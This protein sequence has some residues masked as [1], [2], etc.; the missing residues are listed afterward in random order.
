MRERRAESG[1]RRANRRRS[2]TA[3]GGITLIEVLIAMFVL[4][5]G[6][7]GVAALLPVAQSQYKKGT[8]EQRASDL[9]TVAFQAFETYGMN[10]PSKW[11]YSDGYPFDAIQP[12]DGVRHVLRVAD[13][14]KPPAGTDPSGGAYWID[15]VPP[16]NGGDATKLADLL[17]R[18]DNNDGTTGWIIKFISG[19]LR[20]QQ[21][22]I[23]TIGDADSPNPGRF[24]FTGWFYEPDPAV[25]GEKKSLAPDRPFDVPPT[26]GDAFILIRHQPFVIDPWFVA[27]A[28]TGGT[29]GGM[30]RVSISARRKDLSD[31][32]NDSITDE[33][34]YYPMGASLAESIFVSGDDLTFDA[35]DGPKEN[36]RQYWSHEPYKDLNENGQFDPGVDEFDPDNDVNGNGV[37][38]VYRRAYDANFSW[39]AMLAP[40]DAGTS[41]R[42]YQLSTVVFYKRHLN[43]TAT[44]L[45]LDFGVNGQHVRFGGGSAKLLTPGERDAER[46]EKL[47]PGQWILVRMSWADVNDPDLLGTE[48]GIAWG[49]GSELNNVIKAAPIYRWYRLTSVGDVTVLDRTQ[50]PSATNPYA[51]DVTLDGPD[52]RTLK[53]ITQPDGTVVNIRSMG[54]RAWCWVI[55]DIVGVFQRTIEVEDLPQGDYFN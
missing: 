4:A 10:R 16:S 45:M 51:L 25:L 43:A 2:W 17:E 26:T 40:A 48:P 21:R 39:L 3:R 35:P 50:D 30:P 24:F 46:M 44:K 55:E 6:L 13:F 12:V 14:S 29:F 27:S 22:R 9:A 47:R 19:D 31:A 11:M 37:P 15:Y 36:S 5:V 34:I 28:G 7:M 23:S 18:G 20:G 8:V 53:G 42:R 38:D 32:D 49:L 1:E 54:V 41:N 33:W 52:W